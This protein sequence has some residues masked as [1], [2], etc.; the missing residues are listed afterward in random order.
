MLFTKVCILFQ[1]LGSN[2]T[3][4]TSIDSKEDCKLSSSLNSTHSQSTSVH[5]NHLLD[6]Y[7]IDNINSENDLYTSASQENYESL[8]QD[9]NQ[10]SFMTS[11]RDPLVLYNNLKSYENKVA[12]ID[13][14]QSWI[15]SDCTSNSAVICTKDNAKVRF[16]ALPKSSLSSL[17][18]K[19]TL[20]TSNSKK[21]AAKNPENQD[22]EHIYQTLSADVS[23]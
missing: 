7:G 16:S 3:V 13:H 9:I 12:V 11:T 22:L 10:I 19:S 14:D 18:Q 2:V 23:C 5:I 17:K 20:K 6:G 1:F 8:P 15:Y 4:T 21:E